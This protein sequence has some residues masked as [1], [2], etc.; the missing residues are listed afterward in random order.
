MA[1]KKSAS[2][3]KVYQLKITLKYIE[4]EIWRRVLVESDTS[5]EVLHLI[6]QEAMGW[7]NYHMHSWKIGNK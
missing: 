2:T 3:P 5:L 6:V 4:P 1:T 7:D